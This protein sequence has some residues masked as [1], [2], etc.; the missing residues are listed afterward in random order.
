MTVLRPKSA[1]K[2]ASHFLSCALAAVPLLGLVG[3]SAGSIA[4][5]PSPSRPTPTVQQAAFFETKVRPVLAEQCFS[6]HGPTLQLGGVRLDTV[7]DALKALVPG[8]PE[9]S[10]LIHVLRYD[11]KVKMPPS[12]KLPAAAITALTEWVKMGAPWPES[13]GTPIVPGGSG[14]N[15]GHWAFQPVKKT[16]PPTVKN[17]AWIKSPIDRFVLAK[18]EAKNLAPAP[19]AGKRALIRR[20]YFDLIGL[21]PT[22]EE[23]EAF[24]R[25]TSPDA[26]AKVVDGL[27]TSPHYGERW[28]RHWLDVARYADSNGLDENKAFANAWRYRD[29]VIGATNRDKPYD[30]F[31]M[32]QLAGDLMDSGDNETLRNERITATGFLTLGAKVLAEQDKPKLVMDIVD[33]QIDVVTKA[34]LGLTVACARCHDHKFDP[35]STKDYYAL[36]GIFKSTKTMKNLAFVSEWNS[37]SLMSKEIAA[38]QKQY[39]ET[40]LKP[41]R[42]TLAKARQDARTELAE[43]IARD[44]EKYIA[45]GAELAKQSSFRPLLAERE[46]KP[47]DPARYFLTA[48]AFTKGNVGKGNYGEG[49]INTINTDTFAEWEIDLPAAGRYQIELRYAAEESRPVTLKAN[50]KVIR[51]ETASRVTGSWND[52]GQKWEVVGLFPLVAGKNVLRIERNGAPIPHINKLLVAG[53]I[54]AASNAS[55][56]NDNPKSAEDIAKASGLIADVVTRFAQQGDG[57]AKLAGDALLPEKAER[58]YSADKAAKVKAADDVVKASEAKRPET[59]I[60]MAVEDEPKI[61]DVKVHLRGST[62]TLGDVAPRGFPVVLTQICAADPSAPVTAKESGRLALAKWLARPQHP[63]TARVAVNRIWQHLFGE[64]LVRTPDNWGVR[65]EKPTHPEL[66][67]WLAATFVKE[68]GWSQKKM[69]RRLMLTAAYQQSV[70]SPIAA[71]AFPLDPENR[72]LWKMNRRRLEAEPL[73]DAILAVSGTLDTTMGGSL[74]DTKDNDYVTNDQ[75]RDQAQYSAPRRG[76]YL[77]IIRNAIYDLFQ[78]FDFGDGTSV[79]AKRAATNVAPQALFLL[80]SPLVRDASKAF[81]ASLLTG[82]NANV[83]EEVR[84]RRAYYRALGRPA[85]EDDV[86]RSL[87]YLNRYDAALVATEPDATKRRERAWQSLCQ[88]LFAA[89]EFIYVN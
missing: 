26:F 12:G 31:L 40:T 22:P 69:I 34:T 36:A 81:A 9:K 76:I 18:L 48:A 62:L 88:A 5:T 58:F 66:L 4:Q 43:R 47:G 41:A 13:K 45:A 52:D 87:M 3:L 70:T 21:P 37:R 39:D 30:Q 33:E 89:N 85:T 25:D 44:R 19:A 28:A 32:E 75:S 64:G 60:V 42:A 73:R 84:M 74:L 27:L 29:W 50:G 20:A 63:L 86:L 83:T 56:A 57:T 72:L 10:K 24:V 71:K 79:N 82:P 49:T 61:E 6:C 65:G 17:A 80:N 53:P 23:V 78:S 51:K 68:D 1:K 77:P 67:D 8:D 14:K 2:P 46:A 11:G 35:I 16:T 38:A 15:A 55:E 7:N 54:A 59:P